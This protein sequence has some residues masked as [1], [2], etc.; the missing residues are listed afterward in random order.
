[1]LKVF[2]VIGIG[3]SGS[4]KTTVLK[5][6]AEKLG[7]TYVCT[8]DIR[9]EISGDASDQSFTS[10]VWRLVYDRVGNALGGGQSVVVDATN[11]KQI[12]RLRLVEHCRQSSATDIH[13]HWFQTP[14]K[15]CYERNEHRKRMVAHFVLQM[16]AK[17]LHLA[18]PSL[19][20]GFDKII[21]IRTPAG[22]R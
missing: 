20:E 1:M 8:D 13:G 2:A 5:P 22:V 12:D 15:V 19:G 11:A 7:W 18:P 21:V 10:F 17:H 16:Q 3:I 6:Q 14:F 4:G 9:A